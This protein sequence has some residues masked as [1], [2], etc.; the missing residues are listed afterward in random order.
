[1]KKNFG[2]QST[3]YPM[4]VLIVSAYDENGVPCAMNAAW[5]GM[6]DENEVGICISA[7]HKTTKNI[8]QSGA[9]CVSI[10]DEKHV[11]EADYLG[12][13]SGKKCRIN[14]KLQAYTQQ[15][16]SLSMLRY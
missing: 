15:N 7:G 9:F 8:R 2:K 14:L 10:A 5:G 1:M 11:V 16:L 4:P 6:H 13:E 12:V 3:L